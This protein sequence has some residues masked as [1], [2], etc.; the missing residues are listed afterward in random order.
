MRRTWIIIGL[1]VVTTASAAVYQKGR[2][3]KE[4]HFTGTRLMADLA[5]PD[6]L[7]RTVS[8]SKL[9]HDLLTV[10][11]ARD[12]LTE[13][14]AFYYEQNEDRLG[15]FGAVKR[16]A[17]EHHL[18][19]SDRLLINILNE[20]AEVGLWRDGKGALRHYAIVMHRNT[21]TRALQ[22]AADVA[23]KD[24][25][26]KRAGEIDT[27]SGKAAVFALEINPRRTFLFVSQG[28]RIVLLSDPGMLFNTGNK[29]VPAARAAV[30]G[31]LK[32]EGALAQQFALDGVNPEAV[33]HT[34]AVGTPT[35]ALGYGAFLKGFN[36]L[37]FDFGGSWST[38]VRT[39]QK[40]LSDAM[41]GDAR[42][43]RAAS[44]NPAACIVL[45]VDWPAVQRVIDKAKPPGIAT[46][47]M[48]DGP[49]LACWYGEST[50]YSPVFTARIKKGQPASSASM[51]A[52]ADWSIASGGTVD[53]G[54]VGNQMVWRG[55]GNTAALA[56]LGDYVVFSPDGALV[57]KA[58]DTIARKYPSVADQLPASDTTLALMMPPPLSKMAEQEIFKALNGAADANLL[59]A[60]QTHLPARMLALAAYPPYRLE[61]TPQR[62][63]EWQR[64]EW[65]TAVTPR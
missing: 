46:F 59:A 35:L 5:H 44:A 57:D 12:V 23:L 51:Q 53:K 43:W 26:L 40:G 8:L 32:T 2:N 48:L 41:P 50:L 3:W 1:L 27:G 14:L 24:S 21:L 62:K 16:I 15:L 10:P 29:I 42:L 64:V 49:A 34:L 55:T 18:D 52:L 4:F 13:D 58:L 60:A 11:I 38:S 36:G 61:L 9:P 19:W 47:A 22:A 28:E 37:R 6:A 33:T 7:I 63:G 45:P 39:S 31:W 30:T 17:Y 65:R 20:P 25:Q 54:S 56:T